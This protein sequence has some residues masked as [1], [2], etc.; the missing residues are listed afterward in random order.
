M[1]QK[2]LRILGIVLC[3]GAM[4][5]TLPA[6]SLSGETEA[7]RNS[8]KK[9]AITEFPVAELDVTGE[10]S[11]E[12]RLVAEN[13]SL[14]LYIS[15]KTAE[16]ALLNKAD[17]RMI[18]SNPQDGYDTSELEKST[19]AEIGSQIVLEYLN[20]SQVAGTFTSKADCIDK[21]QF[22]IYGLDLGA[23]VEMTIGRIEGELVLPMVIGRQVF[24]E[25]ILANVESDRERNRLRVFYRLLAKDG[26]S[27]RE[28]NK[29][30]ALYPILK[31]RDIYVF[32]GG[33]DTEQR[34]LEQIVLS[35]GFTKERLAEVYRQVDYEAEEFDDPVFKLALE[36]RLDGDSL[37]V[38]LDSSELTFDNSKF[39]LNTVSILPYFGAQNTRETEGELFVPDGSGALIDFGPTVPLQKQN[40]MTGDLYGSDMAITTNAF[41]GKKYTY[42]LPVFGIRSKESS[43]LAILEEGA[44]IG[45]IVSFTTDGVNPYAGSKARYLFQP[46]DNISEDSVRYSTERYKG[47]CQIRYYPL[48]AGQD[49][50]MNMAVCYRQYLTD[51]GVFTQTVDKTE[52]PLYLETLGTV[53]I[54][55]K[56]LGV[57][58][59]VTAALSTYEDARHMLEKFKEGGTSN[60][61]LRYLG[62]CNGGMQYQAP[63][64]MRAESKLGG[65]SG[66]LKLNEYAVQA[67]IGLYPDVDFRFVRKDGLFDGFRVNT[68]AVQQLDGTNALHTQM[69]VATLERDKKTAEYILT[70]SRI[71]YFFD[72]FNRKYNQ[73]GIAGLSVGSLGNSHTADYKGSRA[74]DLEEGLMYAQKAL[75]R[76]ADSYSLLTEG[77]NAYIWPYADHIVAVPM[78]SSCFMIE[79]KSIPFMALVL[80]G[81][82][83]YSG[84]IA[85]LQTDFRDMVLKAAETGSGLYVTLAMQNQDKLC[86][87]IFADYYS[88]DFAYWYEQV[89]EAMEELRQVQRDTYNLPITAHREVG[90]DVFAT[91]FGEHITIY[92]N[93]GDEAQTVEGQTIPGKGMVAV[94]ENGISQVF[95]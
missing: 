48:A 93:Y 76:M 13:D 18:W 34:Q 95:L 50:Y 53:K 1:R 69:N 67:G 10:E 58:Q 22:S 52:P 31:T 11:Q 36:Y 86:T 92:V 77:G 55:D 27:E 78:E 38:R 81:Y 30:V 4:A 66:L 75:A 51:A 21:G 73:M 35:A 5:G 19:A 83:E 26:M 2:L 91:R 49:D 94:H 84:E 89:N 32:R 3:I 16:I 41:Y 80:H 28:Y 47:G 20:S 87:T 85:N 45:S 54:M 9:T 79:T 24:E 60:L 71:S 59:K 44:A 14:C 70:P 61:Q 15:E 25:E 64:G 65:K 6:E 74:T 23:R 42:H 90:K 72:A 88:I 57:E 62:W 43:F 37:I 29:Q 17:N 63:S 40:T 12:M 82:R 46:S 7:E 68:D 8:E 33:S 39:I 56:V